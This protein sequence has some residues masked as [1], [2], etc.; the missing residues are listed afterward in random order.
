MNKRPLIAIPIGDPAGIGPEIVVKAMADKHVYEVC[1]PVIIGDYGVIKDACRFSNLNLNINIIDEVNQGKYEYGII[2]L[3]DLKN[4]D[5][6]KLEYGKEIAMCGIAAYE[7]IEKCIQLAMDKKVDVVSTSTINKKSL[8]M[9]NIPFIGHTEIFG[10]LTNSHDPLTMFEVRGMRVFFL[11]RHVALKKA[12]DMVTKER[13]L[14]YINRCTI[15]LNKLGVKDPVIAIAGLNPH[16]GEEGL[17]GNEEVESIIPAVKEANKLGYKVVGPIG[18]DSVFH[19]A[20]QG[21]Y[22]AVLS[23]YHDQGHIATKTLDFEKTISITTGMPF[24]RTS[25]DHGTALDIAGQGIASAVSMIE[26]IYLGAKYG[27]NYSKACEKI[28]NKED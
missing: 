18:A 19:L 1:K 20:L 8:K 9:G 13:L 12:C 26:A 24:L 10:K 21:R 7:Y 28:K 16:S 25:V 23:L 3:I 2:D 22:D 15:E 27:N 6:S 4:I 11:S 14:D 17:F 5:M